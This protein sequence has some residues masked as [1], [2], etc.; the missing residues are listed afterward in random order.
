MP[1]PAIHIAVVIPPSKRS[2]GRTSRSVP[3][4]PTASGVDHI[5][6]AVPHPLRHSLYRALAVLVQ[7]ARGRPATSRI[8]ARTRA[9]VLPSAVTYVPHA[10]VLGAMQTFWVPVWQVRLRHFGSAQS[11]PASQSLSSASVQ[12]SGPVGVQLGAP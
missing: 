12:S 9:W 2:S 5:G 10:Q 8:E 4:A 6:V 3:P 1:A 11:A 7:N